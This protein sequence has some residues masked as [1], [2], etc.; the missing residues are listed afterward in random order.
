MQTSF[1]EAQ[2]FIRRP[3]SE[4]AQDLLGKRLVFK[5]QQG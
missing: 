2:F 3:T 1:D 5:T 4:I